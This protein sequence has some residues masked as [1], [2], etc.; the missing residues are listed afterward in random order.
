MSREKEG[1]RDQLEL[2]TR[3]IEEKY[4]NSL[5]MLTTEQVA[6]FLGCNV[7]TVLVNIN[8]KNNPLPAKNIGTGR[9]IWRVPITGLARWS[10]G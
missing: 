6:D 4:P 3:K 5:G 7:K 9:K 1:F 2:V 10:L 8:R